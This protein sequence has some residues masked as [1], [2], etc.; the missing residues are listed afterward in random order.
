MVQEANIPNRALVTLTYI[1]QGEVVSI[2][3]VPETG[4][5][6]FRVHNG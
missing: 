3:I 1:L 5:N 6:S 4:D 2:L